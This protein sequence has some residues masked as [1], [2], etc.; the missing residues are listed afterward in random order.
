[1]PKRMKLDRPVLWRAYV[2]SSVTL[3]VE[4]LLADVVR[5]KPMYGSKSELTTRLLTNW[6]VNMETRIQDDESRET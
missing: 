5:G 4:M 6:L 1:M 3:R 2:P